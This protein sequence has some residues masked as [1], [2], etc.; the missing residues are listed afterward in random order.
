MWLLE[1]DKWPH[2]TRLSLLFGS[3]SDHKTLEAGHSERQPGFLTRM[4][5]ST[6]MMSFTSIQRLTKR[7]QVA[8]VSQS[9]GM[10]KIFPWIQNLRF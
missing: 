5:E 1:T 6:I 2:C 4:V 8:I 7:D 10:T 9:A 3:K